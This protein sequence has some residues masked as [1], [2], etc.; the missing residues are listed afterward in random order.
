MLSIS[1]SDMH[2]NPDGRGAKFYETK[3]KKCKEG[4]FASQKRFFYSG[5]ALRTIESQS[6][7]RMSLIRSGVS[8][9]ISITYAGCMLAPAGA[10]LILLCASPDSK[11][12][13]RYELPKSMS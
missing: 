2:S 13:F 3:K 5:E 1:A 12:W 11:W 10:W 9:S 6:G 7:P 8:I 4:A